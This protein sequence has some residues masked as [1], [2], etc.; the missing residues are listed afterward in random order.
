ME[1]ET[2]S[3]ERDKAEQL[4]LEYE[5]RHGHNR[6]LLAYSLMIAIGLGLTLAALTMVGL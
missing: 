4:W 3:P 6:A 5:N 1:R 2:H